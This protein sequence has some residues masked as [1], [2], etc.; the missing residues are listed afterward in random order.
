MV[1]LQHQ[2]GLL[3][4]LSVTET[5]SNADLNYQGAGNGESRAKE[6]SNVWDEEW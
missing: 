4:R 1:Q 2:Q 3:L 5:R 6:Q